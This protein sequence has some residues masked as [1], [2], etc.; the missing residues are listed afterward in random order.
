MEKLTEDD[1]K[2]ERLAWATWLKLSNRKIKGGQ[3]VRKL[4]KRREM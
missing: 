1:C 2:L 3:R 4:N